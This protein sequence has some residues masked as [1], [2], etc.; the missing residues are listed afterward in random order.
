[1]SDGKPNVSCFG[2]IALLCGAFV[3]GAGL[4]GHASNYMTTNNIRND[5]IS[6]GVGRYVCDPETGKVTF[7]WVTK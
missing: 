2:V 5:A 4:G 6:A 1:M 7:E 3:I